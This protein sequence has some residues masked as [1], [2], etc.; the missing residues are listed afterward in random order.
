MLPK[1]WPLNRLDMFF[2]SHFG[3]SFWSGVPWASSS[4]THNHLRLPSSPMEPPVPWTGPSLPSSWVISPLGN[5][6]VPPHSHA[7]PPDQHFPRCH[8][9]RLWQTGSLPYSWGRE[10]CGVSSWEVLLHLLRVTPPKSTPLSDSLCFP[11]PIVSLG[12]RYSFIGLSRDILG[13]LPTINRAFIH[14]GL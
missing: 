11:D 6:K 8:R 4:L 5:Q 1:L 2:S 10:R 14:Y 9:P 3:G 12:F 7:P 13:P